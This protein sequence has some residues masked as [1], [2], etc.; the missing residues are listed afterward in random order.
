MPYTTAESILNGD[1]GWRAVK[2]TTKKNV[3]RIEYSEV[4]FNDAESAIKFAKKWA[5]DESI[6]YLDPIE[7]FTKRAIYK[8]NQ[9]LFL[10]KLQEKTHKIPKWNK[11]AALLSS[12]VATLSQYQKGRMLIDCNLTEE[13]LADFLPEI[14]FT[15]SE[16]CDDEHDKRYKRGFG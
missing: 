14:C 8:F 5:R 16:A 11:P 6:E 9:P 4:N 3:E 13:E 10:K 15:N 12:G 1:A 2:R 7:L